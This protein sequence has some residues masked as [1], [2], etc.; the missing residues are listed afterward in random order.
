VDDDFTFGLR[1]FALPILCST[2]ST[3]E[4]DT[5]SQMKLHVVFLMKDSEEGWIDEK[6]LYG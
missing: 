5:L 3:A 4:A 6:V 2:Q 1:G